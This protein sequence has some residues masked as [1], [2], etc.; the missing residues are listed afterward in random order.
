MSKAARLAAFRRRWGVEEVMLLDGGGT[1]VITFA[2]HARAELF[3]WE[4]MQRELTAI[5][6]RPV[7]LLTREQHAAL[8]AAAPAAD[9]PA[10][11]A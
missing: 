6:G 2:P 1:A 9:R 11:A 5:F 3:A 10:D 4:F 8:D 7:A